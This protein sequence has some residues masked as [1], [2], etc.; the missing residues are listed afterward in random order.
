MTLPQLFLYSIIA[1]DIAVFFKIFEKAGIEKWKAF[2]PGYNLF[3]W[4]KMMEKPW[5]WL[6]LFIFPGVNFLMFIILNVEL[7]KTFGLRKAT[8]FAIAILLPHVMV[9]KIAF[10]KEVKFVGAPDY[11]NV[12][13]GSISDWSSAIIFALIAAAIIRSY[14]FEAFTI[15]TGSM[16]R[17]LR[18]GDFLFVNK[19]AYGP[20]VPNTP[21]YLPIVHNTIPVVGTKSYLEWFEMG[22]TRLPGFGKVERNDVVVFNFP[23]GDTAINH[24][25][26]VAHT[27]NQILRD[28]AY[29]VYMNERRGNG[30]V[31]DFEKV[32]SRYIS[33]VKQQ[34]EDEYG[35]ITR[36]V[37][38][39]ENYIKRCVGLPGDSIEI[40]DGKVYFNGKLNPVDDES[41]YNYTVELKTPVMFRED[42]LKDE[43][44]LYVSEQKAEAY[45]NGQTV[46]MPLTKEK[47]ELVK[48]N[49]NVSNV[50][51]ETKP[52]GYYAHPQVGRHCPIFPND[53]AFADWTEDNMGPFYLPKKGDNIE[54]TK[55][56]LI[57]YRRAIEA[58]EKNKVEIKGEQIFINDELATHYTFKMGYYW[59][60][61]DNRH[62]SA[63]SRMWGY[64]PEDHVVGRASFVWMSWDPDYSFTPRW[65]RFF[66]SIN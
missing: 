49:P 5:W 18:I 32:K 64:V 8:D 45:F 33:Y 58:Y 7:S 62:N 2:V 50:V 16:E 9:L 60:M 37:D 30:N 22:Y 29:S 47:L 14:T 1:I 35:L 51:V 10:S 39:R 59:L 36:P 44:G 54:L 61:G 12:K 46:S 19:T 63:D 27:Y 38:K 66:K 25:E 31:Y 6:F 23:A 28:R 20:K 17:S 40:I 11:S 4:L 55:E 3:C 15:P 56:N 65:N 21:L 43:F 42:V 53:V 48:K 26:L 24:P 41:M 34:L 57:F 13:R 52:K